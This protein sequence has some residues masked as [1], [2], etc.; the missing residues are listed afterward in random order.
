M[1]RHPVELAFRIY[2]RTFRNQQFDQLSIPSRHGMVDYWIA[3]SILLIYVST[4]SNQCL[5]FPNIV[6]RNCIPKKALSLCGWN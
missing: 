6:T 4:K 5:G 2:V 3:I 1:E